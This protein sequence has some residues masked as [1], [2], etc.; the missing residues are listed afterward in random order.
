[1]D[2]SSTGLYTKD[3]SVRVSRS[4]LSPQGA[5]NLPGTR[6]ISALLS[7]FRNLCVWENLLIG[8]WNIWAKY[9]VD[10]LQCIDVHLTFSLVTLKYYWLFMMLSKVFAMLSFL[11]FGS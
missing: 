5:I 10:L 6:V 11:N 7:D 8:G 2:L 1:M 3:S 4:V 9:K